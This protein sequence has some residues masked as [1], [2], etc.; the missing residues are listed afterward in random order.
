MQNPKSPS[1]IQTTGAKLRTDF[2]NALSRPW[3]TFLIA[4]ALFVALQSNLGR[5]NENST[6]ELTLP[7]SISIAKQKHPKSNLTE[8]LKMD[9]FLQQNGWVEEIA[10]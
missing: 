10:H 6:D 7:E 5:N 2:L 1:K 8:A 9:H 3:L 4:I